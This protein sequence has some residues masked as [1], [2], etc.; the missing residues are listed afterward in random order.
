MFSKKK[1]PIC[2]TKSPIDATTC[3][4]CDSPFELRQAEGQMAICDEAIRLNPKDAVGYFNRG[5]AYHSLNKMKQAIDNYDEAIRLDPQF[6][7]AYH[8]RGTTYRNLGQLER[9]IE[10]YNHAIRLNPKD[11]VVYFNRGSTNKL[12]GK[13]GEAE[14]DFK[15]VITLTDNPQWVEIAKQQIDELSK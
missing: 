13:K 14:D 8:N 9:A 3:A 7:D 1:C 5:D 11:A 12:H 6:A 4:S 15:K 10:D 2:G